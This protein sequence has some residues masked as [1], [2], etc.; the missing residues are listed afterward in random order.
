MDQPEIARKIMNSS[1]LRGQ[2]TL[3]SGSISPFYL[4][5][6]R[7]ESDPVLLDAIIDEMV[8]LLPDNVERL[9][10]MEMGGIPLAVLLSNKTG[11]PALFIRKKAKEYGTCNLVEGGYDN[12]D[13]AVVIEDVIT[14]AGQVRT[15]IRQMRDIGLIIDNVVCVIDREEGG[16]ENLDKIGCGLRSLFTY[17][18]LERIASE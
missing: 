3:R 17:R 14:T 10:G 4:D 16:G 12:G 6:Y 9:A 11:I 1:F 13:R 15:S 7:F 2:F 18:E 5:K 8:S